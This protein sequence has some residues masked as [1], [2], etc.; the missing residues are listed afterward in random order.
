MRCKSSPNCTHFTFTAVGVES[1]SGLENSF[2]LCN[3][4]PT[5]VSMDGWLLAVKSVDKGEE[6]WHWVIPKS[7]WSILFLKIENNQSSN[8]E[9]NGSKKKRWQPFLLSLQFPLVDY[10]NGQG[11]PTE[12][13]VRNKGAAK[14]VC[15]IVSPR[16]AFVSTK[17]FPFQE[18]KREAIGP[19]K[20]GEL[21]GQLY[22]WSATVAFLNSLNNISSEKELVLHRFE[23]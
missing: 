17:I 23:N 22:I 18:A 16:K 3:G 8:F 5:F 15:W 14:L 2:W 13:E 4:S 10:D 1:V 19:P 11:Y 20:H 9:M 7:H 21:A 12:T 6:K